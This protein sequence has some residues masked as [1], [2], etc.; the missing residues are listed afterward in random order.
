MYP[1]VGDT[2]FFFGPQDVPKQKVLFMSCRGAMG[3][4]GFV[5]EF[6]IEK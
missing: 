2:D 6:K 4:R 5:E 1:S 3:A